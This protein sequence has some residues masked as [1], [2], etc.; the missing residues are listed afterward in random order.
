[1]NE[2]ACED[3]I[4]LHRGPLAIQG[5]MLWIFAPKKLQLCCCKG[6]CIA[7]KMHPNVLG[8]EV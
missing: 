4:L 2:Q 3:G 6:N 5:L 1:M 7:L 8:S